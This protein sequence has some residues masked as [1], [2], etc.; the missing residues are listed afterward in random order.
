MNEKQKAKLAQAKNKKPELTLG[1]FDSEQ[2]E[3]MHGKLNALYT[4]IGKMIDKVDPKSYLEANE[5][6]LVSVN[7]ALVELIAKYEQGI[8]VNNF[9]EVKDQ[10]EELTKAVNSDVTVKNQVSIPEGLATD[11]S[12]KSLHRQ[13]I[14]VMVEFNKAINRPEP[15]PDQSAE[16]Y[17]PFRRVR[18]DGQ[19]LVFDDKTWAT[20]GGGGGGSS[21]SQTLTGLLPFE[22]DDLI[23]TNA[24]ANGNYQTGTVKKNGS[25]LAT[26]TLSFDSN[27]NL[28]RITRA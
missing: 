13:I 23:F 4:I 8:N 11:E 7:N 2:I 17:V 19:R 20:G 10:L 26:L 12:I 5:K 15:K 25:T 14:N 16:A 3:S 1:V 27:S 22:F 24:D 9:D 21:S 18:Y 28:T 6:Q